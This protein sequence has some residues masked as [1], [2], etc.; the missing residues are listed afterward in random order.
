MAPRSPALT[1]AHP[2][3]EIWGFRAHPRSPALIKNVKTAKM[4]KYFSFDWLCKRKVEE[5]MIQVI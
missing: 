5:T 4:N 1:R 2:R 3:S